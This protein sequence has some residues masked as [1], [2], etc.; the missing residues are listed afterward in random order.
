MEAKKSE[1]NQIQIQIDRNLNNYQSLESKVVNL[2]HTELVMLLDKNS[3]S[4]KAV[5]VQKKVKSIE[6]FAN[7]NKVRNKDVLQSEYIQMKEK[8]E[9][10]INMIIKNAKDIFD[11]EIFKLIGEGLALNA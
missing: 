3:I 11:D 6:E 2:E 8:N 7:K 4:C 9:D 10:L 1:W 5:Q